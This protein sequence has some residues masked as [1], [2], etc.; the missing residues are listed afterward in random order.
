MIKKAARDELLRRDEGGGYG[1]D[2]TL[3]ALKSFPYDGV[4][5]KSKRSEPCVHRSLCDRQGFAVF[6]DRDSWPF[7]KLQE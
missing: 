1:V 4:E 3:T 7:V 6:A 5:A 2:G